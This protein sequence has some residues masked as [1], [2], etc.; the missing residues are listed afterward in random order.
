MLELYGNVAVGMDS[1]YKTTMWYVAELL[2]N[3]CLTSL[4]VWPV[5]GSLL[6][7][8][9]VGVFPC[10]YWMWWTTMATATPWGCFLCS[11]RITTPFPRPWKWYRDGALDWSPR[12]ACAC[13]AFK[14]MH[15]FVHWN[16]FCCHVHV[17]FYAWQIQG[18]R[19]C[20]ARCVR[21]H[22]HCTFVRL[23]PI[24]GEAWLALD[25]HF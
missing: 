16:F 25:M 12:Y 6:D 4:R 14:G 13:S 11:L 3:A 10:F 15:C 7:Y 2:V 23:P 17:D 21:Q 9:F 8:S 20:S 18:R 24:A 22:R 19:E 5:W 1:T